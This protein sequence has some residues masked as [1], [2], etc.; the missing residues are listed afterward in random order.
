MKIYLH[1][2][3]HGFSNTYI[4][5][6][7]E[8]MQ[9]IIID[10]GN[11]TNDMIQQIERGPYKLVAALI[12]HNHTSHVQG[13]TTLRKIYNPK[14]YAADYEVAKSDTIVIKGDGVRKIAGFSVGYMSVPGH[15]PDSMVFKI[16]RVMFTGDTLIAGNCGSTNN[17]Y[18]KKTL[19]T[20]IRLK[21]LS[22]HDNVEVM[23][24]HGPPTTIGV[25]KQFNIEINN[26]K[27]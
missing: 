16:G 27:Y 7:K 23:P 25:E 15:S 9:A 24:G 19:L 8:T 22:Q 5:T 14:I 6:N 10:P 17:N 3:I 12:T 20:N 26:N 11:I 13:L 18:A 21:L 1:L 4:V 2:N